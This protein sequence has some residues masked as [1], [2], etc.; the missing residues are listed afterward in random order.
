MRPSASDAPC[1]P[2]KR[3]SCY[4]LRSCSRGFLNRSYVGISNDLSQRIRRH[5]GEITGGAKYTAAGRPWK[6]VCWVRGFQTKRQ[7]LQFE[8][9][10][11]HVRNK[12]LVRFEN[13]AQNGFGAVHENRLKQAT[14]TDLRLR[15]LRLLLGKERWSSKSPAASSVPLEVVVKDEECRPRIHSLL[16]GG[17][18]E[19]IT[20]IA[21]A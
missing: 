7:A 4:L 21:D 10:W 13:C 14:G 3:Y 11:K 1:P 6:F 9:M 17:L 8:Y 5:N 12:S 16:S 2:D 15:K 19:Y 20:L 18:K